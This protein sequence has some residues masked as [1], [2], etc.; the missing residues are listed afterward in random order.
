M[1]PFRLALAGA[2]AVALLSPSALR[3]QSDASAPGAK[4]PAAAQAGASKDALGRDT[5]RGTLLGFMR[6][7]RDGNDEAAAAYLNTPLRGHAAE[8]LAHQLYIVLDSRLPARLNEVSDQAEGGLANPLKPDIDVVGSITTASGPLSIVLE[9]VG[10]A[11]SRPLWL[12]SRQTLD[13]IPD[14]YD[15]V[16]RVRVE[17]Y[18]P[19]SLKIRI[20]GIG[21]FHWTV[22]FLV[23]P[24]L[25]RLIG[26]LGR[27]ANP[28]IAVWRR[29]YPS[30][31]IAPPG[32]VPGFVRLLLLAVAI[33]WLLADLDL[34]LLERQ[35]WSNVAAM[36]AMLAGVW[37]GLL[38]NA[39]V[40]RYLRRRLTGGHDQIATPLRLVRRV[41]DVLV[42]AAGAIVTL[43]FYGFD[44]T[45][46]LAG[47][48]I[49]G[50]AVALAAQKT[51]ENVIGGLS[52][53]FDKAVR[54]GDFLKLGDLSGTVDYVGLRSTRI[55]T[56]DRTVLSV[57]NGQIANATIETLSSRDKFWFHHF[58]GLRYGTTALQMSAVLDGIQQQLGSHRSVEH[59]S[60]RARF[61][62]VGP[63]SLDIELF[64]Y[65]FADDWVK[66][67]E[68]QE[69]L[70]LDVMEIV[71]RAG[72][73]I[74]FP[75]QMLY[76]ADANPFAPVAGGPA[77]AA[78]NPRAR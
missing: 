47:L 31:S 75:S 35:F 2:L 64:A 77:A 22:F 21:L 72:A 62:R 42:I 63:S 49:G 23:V 1:H 59:A 43:K 53:I 28:I 69:A 15:E 36:L 7:A 61:V 60:A 27:L 58:F 13:V 20:A 16:N 40:E 78:A 8:N 41:A 37:M 66:F 56:L 5:P 50:I 39:Q 74:A 45:A 29:R 30:T 6:A 54:V 57:P 48:G 38:A 52:I 33:R 71:E 55:R 12:F 68:I 18:V 14:V 3:A 25:Y 32:P 24:L 51:L 73:V 11:P 65:I 10:R 34:P 46:A 19:R 17:G 76:F 26:A 4:T 9:R 70:L 67:L 44:P